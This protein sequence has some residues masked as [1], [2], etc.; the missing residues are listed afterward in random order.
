MDSGW[1]SDNAPHPREVARRLHELFGTYDVNDVAESWR[2]LRRYPSLV[3]HPILKEI[4]KKTFKPD[5]WVHDDS[6]LGHLVASLD[7]ALYAIVDRVSALEQE[8]N[9]DSRKAL[10]EEIRRDLDGLLQ[11]RDYT[12]MDRIGNKQKLTADLVFYGPDLWVENGNGVTGGFDHVSDPLRKALFEI[13]LAS[14]LGTVDWEKLSK[15]TLKFGAKGANLPLLKHISTVAGKFGI[16]FAH[17]P[18]YTRMPAALSV[19]WKSGI[20]IRKKAERFFKWIRGREVMIRSSAVFSEDGEDAT[21]AG[22]YRSIR[23]HA[24]ATF[25]EFFSAVEDVY[26]SIDSEGARAYRKEKNIPEEKMGIVI[27]EFEENGFPQNKGYVN[28]SVKNVP[29]LMEVAYEDGLR[30]LA[31]KERVRNRMALHER[32][33]IFHYELDHRRKRDENV[34]PIVLLSYLAELYY[35]KPVQLEFIEGGDYNLALLQSRLLPKSFSEK[36]IIEFPPEEPLFKGRAVGAFD[37]TLPVIVRPHDNGSHGVMLFQSSKF[38]GLEGSAAEHALPRTGGAVVLG[39]SHANS[40]HLET[41][42][43]EK[44]LALVFSDDFA[45][46]YETYNDSVILRMGIRPPKRGTGVRFENLDG[47]KTLRLVSNGLEG[48]VYG[49]GERISKDTEEN[50]REAWSDS[51]LPVDDDWSNNDPRGL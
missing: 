48:R 2:R 5:G 32:A 9:I 3:R 29:D 42:C 43:A 4:A 21:G 39:P 28:T 19:E 10:L 18:P 12:H 13:K 33:S 47:Y 26:R 45:D 23:L 51:D 8:K 36:T 34:E 11:K 24:D 6:S 25:E 37:V 38:G 22:I 35:G 44:E 17:V 7:P 41:V 27:Q 20:D 16:Y 15:E 1:Y 46:P 31:V 50:L 30:P 40:G 14:E 49:V